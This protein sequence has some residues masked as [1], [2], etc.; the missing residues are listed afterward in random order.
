MRPRDSIII[1]Y[2]SRLRPDDV[3]SS[4]LCPACKG[5]RSGERTLSVGMT[6]PFL[7]WRCHRASCGIQGKH[8]TGGAFADEPSDRDGKR[9]RFRSFKRQELP[10]KWQHW[11]ANRFSLDLGDIE[12]ARWQWTPD[13]DGYGARVIMPIFGPEGKVR[14]ENFRSYVGALPKSL[15]N[16]ELA[17]E[18]ICW[19]RIKKYSRVLVITEDQPSALRVAASGA[20]ALALMGTT[21]NLPRAL[22]IKAQGHSRVY[23]C[24]DQ[25]ASSLAVKQVLLF[26]KYI[27]NLR[28]K[29]LT[30]K[31]IKDMDEQEFA[32]FMGEVLEDRQ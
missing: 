5:G 29:T 18:M 8:R 1:E 16:G 31:D 32:A 3:I 11:L 17:E 27:P 7:W 30:N 20:D 2:E 24:L 9:K 26:G 15:V 28:I 21:L 12:Y 25:D 13:Y 19:Y 22:E 23:L 6:G 4:Q 14:G 10:Y